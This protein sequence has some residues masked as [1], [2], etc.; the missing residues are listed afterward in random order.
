M[1]FTETPWPP[2]IILLVVC[3][4][5]VAAWQGSRRGAYLGAVV[6]L[7]GACVGFIYLEE[8]IVTDSERVERH[9]HDLVHAFQRR[10]EKG[11]L[12][13]FSQ[14]AP[15][16]RTM[17][18]KAMELVAIRDDVDVKDVNILI[19]AEGTQAISHFRANATIA[20]RGL[21]QDSYQ[22]SRWELTWQKEAGE[23]KIVGVQRLNPV[24]G[25]KMGVLQQSAQ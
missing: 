24:T 20:I 7:L 10:D 22:P 6:V 18:S 16:Y 11:T 15:E 9:V 19:L 21:M 12:D 4:F 14:Q 8:W 17:V 1:W 3:C 2:I 5:L 23:W 25:E 13:F